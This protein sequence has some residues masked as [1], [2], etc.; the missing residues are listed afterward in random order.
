MHFLSGVMY[1][2]LVILI[3]EIMGRVLD[4]L[5][6]LNH[7]P[8]KVD[9]LTLEERRIVEHAREKGYQ[10]L[11]WD[12]FETILIALDRLAPPVRK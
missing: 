3:Y 6:W 9:A 4:A 10:S 1:G 12:K 2:L 7:P 11:D 5:G 8:K